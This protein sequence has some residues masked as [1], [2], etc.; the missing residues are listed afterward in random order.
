MA[1]GARR[2]DILGMIVR[3][4]LGLSL[5]G[6]VV[7]VVAAFGVTRLFRSLLFDV[8]PTDPLAFAA[9]VLALSLVAFAASA[10][11]AWRATRL[12]P[13]QALRAE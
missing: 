5:S 6:V 12:D 8:A 11:P 4:G 9:A 7:G 2:A 10:V 3:R 13:M 1:L